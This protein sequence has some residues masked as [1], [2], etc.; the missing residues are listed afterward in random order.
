[1]DIQGAF[2]RTPRGPEAFVQRG[3]S[4]RQGDDF[5]RGR[6]HDNN[7]L[8]A[9]PIKIRRGWKPTEGITDQGCAV[10]R[11]RFGADGWRAQQSAPWLS[12]E[13]FLLQAEIPTATVSTLSLIHI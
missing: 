1:M 5:T 10:L 4:I 11:G 7:A 6:A 2:G 9:E 13:S 3:A 8:N 12:A